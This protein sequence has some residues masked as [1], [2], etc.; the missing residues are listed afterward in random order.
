MQILRVNTLVPT[1]RLFG[2]IGSSSTTLR[3]TPF[4]GYDVQSDVTLVADFLGTGMPLTLE[5]V[6]VWINITKVPFP[7]PCAG[8][9]SNPLL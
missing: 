5:T 1:L 9:G 6:S 7:P 3:A 8:T 2:T 4:A